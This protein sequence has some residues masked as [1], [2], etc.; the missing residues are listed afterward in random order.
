[1]EISFNDI[2]IGALLHD[3]GKVIQRASDNPLEK[4]HGKWGNEWLISNNF[5]SEDDLAVKATIAPHKNDEGVF[6]SNLELIWY[7]SDNLA[8]SER[9]EIEKKEKGKWDM[10]T[11]LVS[12]FFKIKNPLKPQESLSEISYISIIPDFLIERVYFE[13]PEITS[14]DYKQIQKNLGNDLKKLKEK[15]LFLPDLLLTVLYKHLYNV[16]SITMEIYE[17]KEEKIEKHPD[18]SLFHH[19]KLTAAI[20]GCMYYYFKEKYSK[21]W[22]SN[23]LLK[24]KILDS[25]EK[26]YLLIGGDISGVQN[27]IYTI[28]SKGALKSLK[29]RSFYLELLTEH[30]I[31]KIL[32]KLRL[33]RCNIIFAGGGHFY[34]LGYN[35]RSSTKAIDEIKQ[36]INEFLFNEFKGSLQFHIE[37][38]E[39]DKKG[40]KAPYEVWRDLSEKLEASKKRKWKGKLH[41]TLKTEGQD[42]DCKTEQCE[43][44]FREDLKLKDILRF[45][46]KI[47]VCGPCHQQYLLGDSISKVAKAEYPVIYRLSKFQED[48]IKIEDKYYLF[49]ERKNQQFEKEAEMIYRINDL[50]IEYYTNKNTI[51]LPMGI[52]Q[53]KKMQELSDVIGEYG[54]ERLAVLRMDVDNLGRIFSVGIAENDRTFSRMASI[55]EWL[56]KFFKYFL[57]TIAEGAEIKPLDITERGVKEKGRKLSIV[58]A[59]GDDLFIIGHWLDVLECAY[60]VNKYFYEYTGNKYITISGGIVINYEHYPVYQYAKD[61]KELEE[62]A[63]GENKNALGLFN[64]RIEWRKFENII[65]RVK[66]FKN[67]LKVEKDHFETDEEKLPKT[68][69]Y[70]LLSLARRFKEEKVLVLPKAAYLISRAK[71]KEG[72]CDPA[73]VA[74]LKEIIMTSNEEEWFITEIA[75]LITLMLM[76]KGGKRNE[77]S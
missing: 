71:V 66:L 77:I 75:T 26:I 4:T 69:F 44:C 3:I 23:E 21:E 53:H 24:D 59:G 18:I 40:F 27:F 46:T 67:F 70:R 45:D 43:V 32:E 1:M 19:S 33:T 49:K 5:F 10:Y 56:N 36:S 37:I 41:N 50:E 52:Y 29:G 30:V 34:I 16:P 60:D 54:V 57:N 35:T 11:P 6:D 55:S 64:E 22:E 2:V 39:F 42:S 63:K 20:A 15:K 12:P 62:K 76:R 8:S 74:K 17:N 61:A 58:Y 25:P 73:D 9:K 51:F 65:E 13:K 68:F 48:V 47:K 28:T 7:E 72:K 31:S 38:V 14:K